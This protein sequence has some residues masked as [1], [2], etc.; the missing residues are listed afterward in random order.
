SGEVVIVLTVI[1]LRHQ[2]LDI[3]PDDL[4]GRVTKDSRRGGVPRLD[5]AVLVDG[6][7]AVDDVI[8]DRVNALGGVALTVE[9][10]LALVGSSAGLRGVAENED[11]SPPVSVGTTVR[12]CA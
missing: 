11:E 5:G 3:L 10:L 2:P 4:A 6:D 9:E 1:G 12:G 8:D 7:D